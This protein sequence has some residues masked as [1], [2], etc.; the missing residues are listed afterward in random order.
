MVLT[1]QI[2]QNNIEILKIIGIFCLSLMLFTFGLTRQE[3]VGF[4]SRFYLF[5]LEMWRHGISWFPTTYREPYPDYPVTSTWLIYF[6]AY[7][8]GGLN[9]TVAVF[10]SAIAAAIT[11]T[12][13]YLLGALHSKRYG[14][15][16]VLLLLM[17]ITFLKCTRSIAL[18][19]YPTMITTACFYVI[20]S[21]DF[22]KKSQRIK[23]ICPLLLLGFAFRGPIGL[24]MPAGVIF[25]YYLINQNYRQ[26]IITSFYS[27]SFLLAATFTLLS[28]AYYVDGLDFARAV[29][30]MEIL[31]RMNNHYQPF[32]F[33]FTNSFNNYAL[34]F[35]LACLV[36]GGII[37]DVVVLKKSNEMLSFL[38]KLIAWTMIIVIGMS[39]PGD[40]KIRYILPAVPA[41]ALL[42]AYPFVSENQQYFSCLRYIF[43]R[44]FLFAPMLFL[45][46]INIIFSY[47]KKQFVHI[48]LADLPLIFFLLMMQLVN[49]YLIFSS[50]MT[51]T[52]RDMIMVFLVT[53]CFIAAYFVAVE[54]IELYIDRAHDF[55]TT[56]EKDRLQNKAQLI[57]Y[58]ERAD[59][60]AI[61]YLINT[62]QEEQVIFMDDEN[63][64]RKIL[65]PS[66][67][68]TSVQYYDQLSVTE[69]IKWRILAKDTLGHNKVV[70]I[71]NK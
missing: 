25:I 29:L 57:F 15:Y 9:K 13:T 28:L 41:L 52:V 34:S 65:K 44:L 56:I 19:M 33:Y 3:V 1:K 48:N 47:A 35:P 27:L 20:Y 39:I 2:R 14:F 70:A 71:T 26:L 12:L 55:V 58:K 10:P 4:D 31:G 50:K 22:L 32:Y 51:S 8:F 17:T 23:F 69:K 36:S 68:L 6:T 49:F 42:A 16:A 7:L 66:I 11:L 54:P 37:Y 46:I 61:K 5:A 18:D 21:A 63:A 40:K 62:S 30:N 43:L 67:V 64:L 53:V 60:L 24:I 38:L 45:L 59:G